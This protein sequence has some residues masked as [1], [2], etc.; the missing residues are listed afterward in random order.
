MPLKIGVLGVRPG[1]T[2]SNYAASLIMSLSKEH[3][4]VAIDGDCAGG[5]LPLLLGIK[6]PDTGLEFFYKNRQKEI[7]QKDLES[8]MLQ[9]NLN[10]KI[11]VIPGFI[12]RCGPKTSSLLDSMKN[13]IENIQKEIVVI[14]LGS[15][16][17]YPELSQIFQEGNA[18]QHFFDYVFVV[19]T[20]DPVL[21]GRNIENLRG[22]RII[23]AP[24]GVGATEFYQEEDAKFRLVM[25]RKHHKDVSKIIIDQLT[26]HLG[27]FKV[28][29]DWL[30][31]DKINDI[32]NADHFTP[33][34]YNYKEQLFLQ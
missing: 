6:D 15:P 9:C 5:N 17:H 3:S 1:S 4:V 31:N 26:Y 34:P 29:N 28:I 12:E 20:D 23:E 8:Q 16:F 32:V 14:D 19:M 25:M 13:G 33:L 2:A 21:A 27:P 7:N 10:D 18:I 30:W 11:T 22:S 24:K